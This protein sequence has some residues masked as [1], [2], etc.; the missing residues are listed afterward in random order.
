MTGYS[1]RSTLAMIV[2]ADAQR[3]TRLAAALAP[4]T[5]LEAVSLHDAFSLVEELRP[6]LVGLSDLVA[7]EAGLEMFSQLLALV[8]SRWVVYGL[9]PPPGLP[10]RAGWVPLLPQDGPEAVVDVLL[11]RDPKRTVLATTARG[12]GI[13]VIGAST[14]GIVA[15]KRVLSGFPAD[16]PPTLIV[17]H[18]RPGFV[19]GMIRRL[20]E[21]CA[22]R[23]VPAADGTLLAR[24]TVYVAADDGCHL[25]IG[26][27]HI[28]ICRVR[29]APDTS[30]F[31][32]S[33]D[34]LFESVAALGPRVAA[35]ILT[36]MGSDG[37]QGMAAIRAA[38]GLTIAQ[39]EA[40]S[41]VY[42][43]PRAAAQSG[44]AMKILPLDAIAPALLAS[45]GTA[46]RW[47]GRSP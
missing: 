4:A 41:T 8:G 36:G 9:T 20:A 45:G 12:P 39:D 31:R 21:C 34:A 19:D 35:V 22:P 30:T 40:S 24:G 37:S 17:Q 18:I 42:G 32:P 11:G 29:P 6:A 1:S 33:V 47:A 26:I 46:S 25:T 7:A 14:G 38:G 3:R 15:I 23:V 13:I 16:C 43:M 44:A 10:V 5:V 28:P 2:D 27:G